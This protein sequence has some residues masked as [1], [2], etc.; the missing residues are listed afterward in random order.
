M[1][2]YGDA[3]PYDSCTADNRK[4]PEIARHVMI[5]NPELRKIKNKVAVAYY[6]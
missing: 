2:F 4:G 6:N 5:L 3:Q 1:V